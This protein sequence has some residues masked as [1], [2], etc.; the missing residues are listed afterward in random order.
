MS[1]ASLDTVLSDWAERRSLPLLTRYKDEEVRAFE[2]VGKVSS[3]QFQLWIDPPDVLG[4][5]I[6]HAWDRKRWR[7]DY[8]TTPFQLGEALDRAL[9][10][11]ERYDQG[12][13]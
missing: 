12:S 3:R 1:Y 11:I 10:E 6:V 13:T 2:V 7:V 5:T 4:K 9:S 8:E